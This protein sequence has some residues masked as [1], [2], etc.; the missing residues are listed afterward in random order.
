[1]QQLAWLQISAELKQGKKLNYAQ[2]C[3]IHCSNCATNIIKYSSVSPF[4]RPPEL[5][6]K[7]P[8]QT[9]CLNSPQGARLWKRLFF[10]SPQKVV[11]F[12]PIFGFFWKNT[13]DVFITACENPLFNVNYSSRWN[14]DLLYKLGTKRVFELKILKVRIRWQLIPKFPDF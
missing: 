10:R 6:I 5:V 12:A 7:T 3:Q 8:S 4:F 9:A 11:Y 1:M 14:F 13:S 2:F